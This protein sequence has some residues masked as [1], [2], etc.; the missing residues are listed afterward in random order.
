MAETKIALI[1]ENRATRTF[2]I[3]A[4][5]EGLKADIEAMKAANHQSR[6][7]GFADAFDDQ[8]FFD[9]ADKLREYAVELLKLDD[10]LDDDSE[11][12]RGADA[13]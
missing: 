13:N 7:L 2:A 3:L 6:A 9:K 11:T 8:A 4:E 12:D 5:I 10:N 1:V